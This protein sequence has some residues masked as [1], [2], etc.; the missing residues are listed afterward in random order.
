MHIPDLFSAK[1]KTQQ[2]TRDPFVVPAEEKLNS[3]VNFFSRYY[4]WILL[5]TGVFIIVEQTRE[6]ISTTNYKYDGFFIFYGEI[7]GII[8]LLGLIGLLIRILLTTLS[9]KTRALK[10]LNVK[11]NFIQQLSASQDIAEV[12][13]S[14]A[15][16]IAL[17]VPSANIELFIHENAKDWFIRV[18]HLVAESQVDKNPYSPANLVAYPCQQCILKN[19]HTLHSLDFCNRKANFLSDYEEQTG[20]CL[21]LLYRANPVGLLLLY[22]SNGQL[23]DAEQSDMLAN[24][25]GE[26]AQAIGLMVEKK[27]HEEARLTEKIHTMQLDIARDL[28]DTVGQNISYL[29]MK[30]DHLSEGDQSVNSDLI[31]EIRSMSKVANESYDLVR[32][33]L[34]VL[35]AEDSA[36]LLYLYSRYA[37]QVAERSSFTID[38]STCGV[39]RNLSAARLRHMFYIFREALNNIEKHAHATLVI[40]KLTWDPTTLALEIVDNGKGYDPARTQKM[41]LHYGQKFMRERATLL[42]GTLTVKSA[43]DVGTTISV[44]I[45]C[46]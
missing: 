9:E 44:N 30:L 14:L 36:D 11:H 26:M 13:K 46:D 23:V 29:R 1:K 7:F 45:P 42:N 40:V 19:N 31:M 16:Q 22:P 12:S 21:P 18:N 17:I 32:G 33:T 5:L 3:A 27:A 20:F 34:A 10:I 38:F 4:G 35:Q 43:L 28:H 25:S 37:K 41:D 39:P 15:Q 2:P 24:L 6:H 8:V